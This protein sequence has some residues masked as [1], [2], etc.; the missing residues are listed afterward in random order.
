MDEQPGYTP[1]EIDRGEDRAFHI[2]LWGCLIGA[3]LLG[4][5]VYGLY[6]FAIWLGF[7]GSLSV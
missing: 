2:P 1:E 4:L 6:R 7:A 5:L 3:A